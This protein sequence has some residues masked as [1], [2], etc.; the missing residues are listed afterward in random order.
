MAAISVGV[1]FKYSAKTHGALP[2]RPLFYKAEH[3]GEISDPDRSTPGQPFALRLSKSAVK[4]LI[5]TFF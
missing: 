4:N 1:W 2:R 3:D 5:T